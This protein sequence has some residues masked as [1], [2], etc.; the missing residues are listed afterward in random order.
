VG[1]GPDKVEETPQERALS[2][3]ASAQLADYKKRWLPVQQ[4]LA[5]QIQ[6]MGEADSFER[7]QAGGK[8]GTDTAIKFAG[9]QG[10]LQKS[11]ANSGVG[12]GSSRGK[13]AVAGMGDD[14]AKSR[15]LGAVIADQQID[16]AYTRGLG[17]LVALGR[18]DKAQVGNSLAQQATQSARQA[19][20][21]AQIS[22]SERQGKYELAGQL[23]GFG[24]QASM[25][26]MSPSVGM[27]SDPTGY[28]GTMN[29]PSAYVAPG[30]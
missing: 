6:Q 23:A 22:L 11:L 17:S 26:N 15:G 3:Y 19:S 18:G 9:A 4:N 30:V 14:E 28:N 10:A 24:L 8:A 7:R 5:S 12:V 16:D 27:G 2:E 29:N 25:A 20:Q 1:K 13:L 21:D